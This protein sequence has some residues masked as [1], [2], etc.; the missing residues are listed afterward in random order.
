MKLREITGILAA[1]FV[2]IAATSG[3]T[4]TPVRSFRS[5]LLA[6]ASTSQVAKEKESP[7]YEPLRSPGFYDL[8]GS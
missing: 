3:S 5:H 8:T 6:P 2:L 1:S 7:W 4:T